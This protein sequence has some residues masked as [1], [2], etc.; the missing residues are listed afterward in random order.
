MLSFV[1]SQSLEAYQGLKHVLE[2]EATLIP[3][4]RGEGGGKRF[5]PVLL[6]A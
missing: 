6:Q 4:N 2:E 1:A 3:T 5:G